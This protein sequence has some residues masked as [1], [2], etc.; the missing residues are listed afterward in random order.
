VHPYTRAL[1]AAIPVKG[2]RRGA[3]QGLAGQVPD[4]IRP[5]PGCRFR[6][7]CPL[8][9]EA[10]AGAPPPFAP[11]GPGHEAACIRLGAEMVDA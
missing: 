8:G 9:V 1:L 3:L 7:R 5:P 11:A 6:P 10:C 4:L 2:V